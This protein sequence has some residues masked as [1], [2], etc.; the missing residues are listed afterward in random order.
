MSRNQLGR[1]H[2]IR[3]TIKTR[4]HNRR[5]TGNNVSKLFFFARGATSYK[6]WDSRSGLHTRVRWR[7]SAADDFG[8]IAPSFRTNEL[9]SFPWSRATMKKETLPVMVVRWGSE[10]CSNFLVPRMNSRFSRART[11]HSFSCFHML[12]DFSRL[13]RLAPSFASKFC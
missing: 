12:V 6:T 8:G 7:R 4:T 1:R 5:V 11:F 3:R 9:R 13:A 2:W 10:R